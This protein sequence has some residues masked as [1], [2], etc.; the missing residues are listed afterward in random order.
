MNDLTPKD[1][2]KNDTKLSPIDYTSPL[3]FYL[4]EFNFA[5]LKFWRNE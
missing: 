4:N 3:V 5:M 2:G 1:P